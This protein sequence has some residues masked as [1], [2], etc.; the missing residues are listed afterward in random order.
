[1]TLTVQNPVEELRA[2]ANKLRETAKNA[3]PGRWTSEHQSWAGDNAVLSYAT[4]GHAVAVCGEEIAGADHP[5]S[6]DA[7]WIALMHPGLAEPL[8]AWLE[9]SANAALIHKPYSEYAG[10]PDHRWCMACDDEECDGLQ[11]VDRA[12]AVARV[13][14]GGAE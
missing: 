10:L 11:N 8:A 1:M 5:A 4:N 13:I 3:T 7:A 14:L 12:A 9:E 6:A 2:A